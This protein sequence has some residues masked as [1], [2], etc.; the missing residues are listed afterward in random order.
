[1]SAFTI[2]PSSEQSPG[3]CSPTSLYQNLQTLHLQSAQSAAATTG[4]PQS[5]FA[6]D[7]MLR[8]SEQYMNGPYPVDTAAP[9]F[10]VPDD[11][12]PGPSS[13]YG[14]NTVPLVH[15][16]L[17][18]IREDLASSE[19]TVSDSASR[20]DTPQ[21]RPHPTVSPPHPVISVTDAL[22]RVM[23][24][25]VVTQG[26]DA[27]APVD[28]I[29]MD[30]C[31]VTPLAGF[32]AG[33]FAGYNYSS[34]DNLVDLSNIALTSTSHS[35]DT[36]ESCCTV[37]P[38]ERSAHNLYY[39]LSRALE[40]SSAKQLVQKCSAESGLFYLANASVSLE[41]RVTC[42]AA[43]DRAGGQKVTSEPGAALTFRHLSGDVVLYDS[44]CRELVSHLRL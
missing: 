11:L 7:V 5:Q 16:N 8:L 6:A 14:C 17:Q 28:A 21:S 34:Y 32:P 35:I 24:V 23:P 30:D 2:D 19:G 12:Q 26:D 29:P 15:P 20:S 10:T 22:G 18:M 44:I 40:S 38:T 39:D 31:N 41:V 43:D 3:E 37:I 13:S 1:M 27:S 42:S 33:Y 25:V 36:S 9:S 4:L